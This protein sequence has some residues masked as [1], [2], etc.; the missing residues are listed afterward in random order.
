MGLWAGSLPLNGLEERGKDI[1]GRR[2]VS[3]ASFASCM[4]N[5]NALFL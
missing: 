3:G 2:A 5:Q 4:P 1:L